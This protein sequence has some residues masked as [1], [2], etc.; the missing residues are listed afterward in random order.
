MSRKRPTYTEEFR[1]DA[2]GLLRSGAK[3]VA[4]VAR[5]LG[6]SA[7]TLRAWRDA[8]LAAGGV[9]GRGAVGDE[10]GAPASAREL[11]EENRRLQKEVHH[12]RRQRDILKKAA[13]ILSEDPGTGT[14]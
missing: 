14:R 12:L 7:N 3:P 1:R 5:E 2:V 9:V 10:A 13:S 4:Q 11:W 6:V 8:Q